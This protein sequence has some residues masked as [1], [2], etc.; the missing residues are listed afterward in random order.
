[1]NVQNKLHQ[2]S[3]ASIFICFFV[4]QVQAGFWDDAVNKV[5][6]VTEDVIKDTVGDMANNDDKSPD[7]PPKAS[8]STAPEEKKQSV[9][10]STAT[11]TSSAASNVQSA[12]V[13][14]TTAS[15]SSDIDIIGL[16]LGMTQ[17]QVIAA[18]KK[19]NKDFDIRTSEKKSQKS[20]PESDLVAELRQSTAALNCIGAEERG[21]LCGDQIPDHVISVNASIKSM[22]IAKETL[23]IEYSTPPS[24]NVVKRIS[25]RIGLGSN[26]T[27]K[28]TVLTALTKKYGP[29]TNKGLH[30]LVWNFTNND[31][32]A[33]SE[34][35]NAEIERGFKRG[36]VDLYNLVNLADCGLVLMMKVIADDSGVVHQMS[37]VLVNYSV[38]RRDKLELEKFRIQKL[39]EREEKNKN[40]A[41]K[42]SAPTL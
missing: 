22:G 5:K 38:L 18:L 30:E 10:S 16:K 37:S 41:S 11:E 12:P 4:P 9:K 25:R 24:K 23:A 34:K 1:M 17:D 3:L 40:N 33:I 15:Q 7:S 36:L 35:C 42:N 13:T 27:L 28:T 31:D 21:E 19:H 8:T 26:G 14:E 39:K 29:P 6:S 20:G 2:I 32:S